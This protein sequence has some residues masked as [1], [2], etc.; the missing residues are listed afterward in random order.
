MRLARAECRVQ[1]KQGAGSRVRSRLVGVRLSHLPGG[2]KER[3]VH[4]LRPR[5]GERLAARGELPG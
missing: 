1:V 2:G 3:I 5:A 4:L